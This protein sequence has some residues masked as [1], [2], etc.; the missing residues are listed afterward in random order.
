MLFRLYLPKVNKLGAIICLFFI[1]SYYKALIVKHCF[2]IDV[3]EQKKM[4]ACVVFPPAHPAPHY[5]VLAPRLLSAPTLLLHP[6]RV[7]LLQGYCLLLPSSCTPLQ[8]A[9][10]P[11]LLSAPTPPHA[12]LYSVPSPRSSSALTPIPAPPSTV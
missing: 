6:Y 12:S 2:Y 3:K 1:C 9:C 4:E 7:C 10:S 8:C 11:R 5:S